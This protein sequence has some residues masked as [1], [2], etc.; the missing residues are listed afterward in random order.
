M[1]DN[2]L[3]PKGFLHIFCHDAGPRRPVK[4]VHF[5]G[6]AAAA[7]IPGQHF[8]P[9]ASKRFLATVIDVTNGTDASAYFKDTGS[10]DGD[11]HLTQ[12]DTG[13]LS[14][15][16]NHDMLAIYTDTGT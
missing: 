14:N 7:E 1:A 13:A 4:V 2:K 15:Y 11:L 5:K 10:L 12:V 3:G 16:T 9:A 8:Y 6:L